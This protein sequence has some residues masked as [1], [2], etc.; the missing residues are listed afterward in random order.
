MTTKQNRWQT[1]QQLVLRN[2]EQ[3]C[4]RSPKNNN[5]Q[6]GDIPSQRDTAG[7]GTILKELRVLHDTQTQLQ[8]IKEGIEKTNSRLYEAEAWIVKAEEMIQNTE[9]ITSE[10]PELQTQLDAKKWQNNR[11]FPDVQTFIYTEYQN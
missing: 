7:M 1:K 4:G 8:E 5:N 11:V 6:D 2:E 10:M 9:D 3:S